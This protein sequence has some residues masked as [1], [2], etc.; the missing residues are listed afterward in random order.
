MQLGTHLCAVGLSNTLPQNGH[1]HVFL[2]IV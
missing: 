2:D 1:V